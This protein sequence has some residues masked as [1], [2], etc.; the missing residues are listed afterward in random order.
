[1]RIIDHQSDTRA[2]VIPMPG[3]KLLA[4]LA[5]TENHRSKI[6]G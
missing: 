2:G 5:V 1:V 3:E 4:A 6:R